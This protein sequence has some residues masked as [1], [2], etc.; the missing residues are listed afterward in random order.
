MPVALEPDREFWVSLESDKDRPD[1]VRPAFCCRAQS[2]RGQ[3][4]ISETIDK[5]KDSPSTAALFGTLSEALSGVV[6]GWR[7]M[8][9]EYS[10]DAWLDVLQAAEAIELLYKVM[11]AGKVDPEQK[12]SS[13]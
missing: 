1:D 2:M 11:D 3:L 7:N 12:K 6:T 9:V 5:L 4:R 13:E 10:P 8:P